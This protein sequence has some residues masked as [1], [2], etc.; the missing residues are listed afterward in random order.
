MNK[1]FVCN[2]FA[3]IILLVALIA[4]MLIGCMKVQQGNEPTATTGSQSESLLG[5]EFLS[6]EDETTELP[7]DN[8]QN[9][10]PSTAE[11][12]PSL[13]IEVEANQGKPIVDQNTQTTK[14][15]HGENN[16]TTKPDLSGSNGKPNKLLTYEEFL[17]LSNEEQ[18]AYFF[19]FADPLDY[20][21]WLQQAQKEYQDSQQ[22]I[23][24]TGPIDL[25][26]LPTG[27]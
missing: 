17:S 2:L 23:V 14:P 12:E 25:S 11:T 7:T 20:A 15:E 10:Q 26:T 1:K 27:D 6:E 21:A 19:L 9:E 8:T 3:V 24:I 18:Q 22:S 5:S 13:E 16:G 4:T